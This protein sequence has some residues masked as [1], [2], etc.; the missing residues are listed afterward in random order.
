MQAMHPERAEALAGLLQKVLRD[1]D[2]DQCRMYIAVPEIGRQ[3]RQAVL[4][5]N[6]GPVPFKNAVHDERVALI[7]ISELSPHVWAQ[8]AR[9]WRGV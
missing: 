1:R 4:S 8:I 5:I 6:A 2:V 7:P 9:G 3:E